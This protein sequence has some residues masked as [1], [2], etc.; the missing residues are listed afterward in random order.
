MHC[1]Q[2]SNS[3]HHLRGAILA[4]NLSPGTQRTRYPGLMYLHA[5]GVASPKGCTE[6]SPGWSVL[7]D[8][9]GFESTGE[10]HLWPMTAAT[11]SRRRSPRGYN[12]TP[13]H[14]AMS[15]RAQKIR[16]AGLLAPYGKSM[17]LGVAAAVASAGLDLL[18][19]F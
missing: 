4:V 13:Q 8:T 5:S 3:S 16:I 6:L 12:V 14:L 17:A 1:Q 19:P 10:S 15:K 18:Q 2:G 7:C 11:V 9:R